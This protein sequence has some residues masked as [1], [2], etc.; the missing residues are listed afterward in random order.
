MDELEQ[1]KKDIQ[2]IKERNARVEMDKAWETSLF[3]KILIAVLTYVVIVIFFTFANLP[4][5]FVNAIV[6][7]LGFLLSTLSISLFKQ[8]WLK[9]NK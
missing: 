4:K 2:E 8:F 1:I 6:P 9:R 3:R 5:P 7:T